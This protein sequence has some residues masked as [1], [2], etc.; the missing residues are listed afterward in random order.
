MKRLTEKNWM[1]LDPWECCGQDHYCK[2]GCA[3]KGGC[4]NGCIVPK[5]YGRLARYEDTGLSPKEIKEL[6]KDV[7]EIT[8]YE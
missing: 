7:E 5:L 6:I 3:E 8:E 2:R 4:I 1:N